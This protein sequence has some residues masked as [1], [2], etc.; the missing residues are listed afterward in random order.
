VS[1]PKDHG[2]VALEGLKE[3]CVLGEHL[4]EELVLPQHLAQGRTQGWILGEADVVDTL[5]NDQESEAMDDK[6]DEVSQV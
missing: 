5:T 1:E 6:S 3:G 2:A 4:L